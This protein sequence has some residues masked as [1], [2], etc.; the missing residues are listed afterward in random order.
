[1]TARSLFEIATGQVMSKARRTYQPVRRN[2]YNVGERE[3]RIWK[4]I[5]RKEISARMRAAEQYNYERKQP[6]Q[7]NGP[8]GHIGLEVLRVLYRIVD[9]K[10]G[11]LDPSIGYLMERLK[12]SRA[13]IVRALAALK[14]HGFL[15]WI[16]RTEPTDNEGAGPQVK[17]ITNAYWFGLPQAAAD[18]VRRMVGKAP[19]P[20][21]D[22]VRRQN[23]LAE[24]TAMLEQVPLDELPEVMVN[25][26][27]LAELLARMGATLEGLSAS[28]L[29]GQNPAI[30]E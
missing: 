19:P 18:M 25:D 20:D 11:R 2:S 23:D 4:P 30:G 16:R 24:L 26:P 22:V 3:H 1:M 7:R 15:N 10:T 29:S 28:S 13:A 27:Y 9:Y 6:G 5:A 14:Q 8:L 12:R 17:Q 21:D